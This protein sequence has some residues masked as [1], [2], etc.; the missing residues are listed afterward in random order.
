MDLGGKLLPQSVMCQTV[1]GC[2]TVAIFIYLSKEQASEA[3]VGSGPASSGED[4]W[5]AMEAE[6][7]AGDAPGADSASDGGSA[8]MSSC[9]SSVDGP[10]SAAASEVPVLDDDLFGPDSAEEPPPLPPPD[11]Q[12]AG[13]FDQ[14]VAPGLADP[15]VVSGP[16]GA[17]SSSDPL[18]PGADA[19]G[20]R[21]V[22]LLV[23]GG[24]IHYYPKGNFMTAE[25]ACPSHGKCVLTRSC[26]SG[27]DRFQGRPLGLLLA[28]LKKGLLLYGG[29]KEEHWDPLTW[30]SFE[31][32]SAARDAFQASASAEAVE[33]L[34]LERKPIAGE[35]VEPLECKGPKDRL[36]R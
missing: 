13:V 12:P 8:S 24:K 10:R 20:D 21:M 9:A 30:P 11:K 3:E 28:W 16:S 29:A 7:I 22:V 14:P 18:A 35:G 19:R 34:R 1:G 27:G 33:L 6:L 25:C 2:E 26:K 32:R 17:R 36:N 15:T 4:S 31:E 23:P 5:F